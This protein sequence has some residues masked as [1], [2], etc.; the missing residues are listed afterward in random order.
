MKNFLLIGLVIL[1]YTL[2]SLLCKKYS[3]HYPGKAETASPVFTVISGLIVFLISVGMTGFS[4]RASALTVA[5]GI[6]NALALF[7]Y[8]AFLIR[9]SQ[10]GSYSI[11][12][13]FSIA[14]AILIPST[15]ALIGFG[16][17]I[18]VGKAVGIFLVLVAVYLVSYRREN[19]RMRMDFLISCGALALCNGAYGSLLD[20]QQ[21][22][23][24][25][26]EKEEM[27]AVTYG[28]A[29]LLGFVSMAAREKKR[30]V[31]CF[32]QTKASLAYLLICSLTVAFA[33][34]TMVYI[35]PHVNVTLLYTM[36]NAGVFLLSVI[37]SRLFFKDRLSLL[38]V[39]GCVL[40]RGALV[41][42]AAL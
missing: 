37:C 13:V 28:I 11:L 1:L 31:K 22:L 16:D 42:V 36:D 35:L 10:T 14:G 23:C 18:S 27:V 26:A 6:L 33:I 5:L 19:A 38:N 2:Q 15:V 40:M 39:G 30:S 12:M 4:F 24:G 32:R 9:A 34:H 25:V 17:P 21:R 3:D 20:V 7:G 41:M 29:A 8:N